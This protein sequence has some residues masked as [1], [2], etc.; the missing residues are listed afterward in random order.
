M[1]GATATQRPVTL[2]SWNDGA[3]RRSILAFV[4]SVTTAGPTYVAPADRIACLDNDGTLWS[5]KPLPVQLDFMM[6]GWAAMALT[7]PSR[8]QFQ[9]YKASVERD[10]EYFAHYDEHAADL[11]AGLA[12]AFGGMT[13]ETFTKRVT[14]F[15]ATARHPTYDRPYSET[16]YLPMREL[17]ELLHTFDFRV[18]I[19]SGGGRDFVRVVSEQMYGVLKERVLGTAS[20]YEWNTGGSRLRSA[21]II[22]DLDDGPD[23][24]AHIFADI[25]RTPIFAA[26]NADGDIEMLESADFALL[27]THDDADRETAYTDTAE[28]AIDAAAAG[29]WTVVSM[30]RDWAVLFAA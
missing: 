16:G 24:P 1:S 25:G 14:A 26:G 18:F 29:G 7:D 19:V 4:G 8:R 5:E 10:M 22:G 20:D 13:P 21:P 2:Q 23:K 9:P 27:V 15:F 6:R 17:I 3:A 30:K 28:R 11:V 12:E